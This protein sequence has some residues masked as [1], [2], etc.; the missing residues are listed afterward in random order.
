MPTSISTQPTPSTTFTVRHTSP[1]QQK[2]NPPLLFVILGT[3]IGIGSVLLLL[4][5]GLLLLRT[6]L[7][8]S[9]K[10]RLPPSGAPPWQR[11]RINSLDDRMN[12]SGHRLQTLQT[13]DV[14]SLTCRDDNPTTDG[15]LPT[16]RN[17]I[18]SRRAFSSI[19]SNFAFKITQLT[20][21]PAHF[22]RR[23]KLKKMHNSGILAEPK[24][25]AFTLSE[26]NQSGAALREPWEEPSM[27]DVPAL[28]DPLVR[29][30]LQYYILRGQ[31]ARQQSDAREQQEHDLG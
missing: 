24:N 14:S 13:L 9:A 27:E 26:Q 28:D 25:S 29:E 1:Y 19:T 30:T 6:Y 20:I 21:A 12:I 3:L 23:T 18:P 10:M 11:A 4:V 2:G 8:P 5:T 22:L 16:M 31:F 15:Y 7:L 17:V